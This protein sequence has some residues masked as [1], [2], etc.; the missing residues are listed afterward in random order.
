MASS[1]L[2]TSDVAEPANPAVAP[3]RGRPARLDEFTNLPISRQ[4]KWQLRQMAHG[5]C[6][7]CGQPVVSGHK[8]LRHLIQ[9]R[10]ATARKHGFK[11]QYNSKS[12]LLEKF[13]SLLPRHWD[14]KVISA[15]EAGVFSDINSQNQFIKD[16]GLAGWDLTA[17]LR[18]PDGDVWFYFKRPEAADL[19]LSHGHH[20]LISPPSPQTTAKPPPSGMTPA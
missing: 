15:R 20:Q 4:R 10:E 19:P 5:G 14:Y 17:A 16:Q 11:S 7:Q 18:E 13:G 3:K 2:K 6:V 1:K 8:C 12:R 9:S